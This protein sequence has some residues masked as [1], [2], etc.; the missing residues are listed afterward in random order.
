MKNI[1]KVVGFVI[2]FM[3]INNIISYILNSDFSFS[4]YTLH[5]LY[6]TE[7][8]I[9]VLL[10]G[11]C[12]SY[13]EVDP[14]IINEKTN[15]KAFNLGTSE[16][17]YDGTY[18]LI[19]EANKN[20]NIKTI[21]LEMYFGVAGK[22]YKADTYSEETFIISDYM[23]PS[24]NKYLYLIN[25]CSKEYYISSFIPSS[26]YRKNLFDSKILKENLDLKFSKNYLN[27]K[28]DMY[29]GNGYVRLDGVVEGG[30]VSKAGKYKRIPQKAFSD[31]DIYYLNKIIKYCK[32]NQIELVAYSSPMPDY[33][34]IQR[35]NYDEYISQVKSLFE[36][37][38]VEYYDFNLLKPEYFDFNIQYFADDEHL[39]SSGTVIFTTLFS[40]FFYGKFKDKDIFYSSYKEK[41]E[42]DKNKQYGISYE[43]VPYENNKLI[44]LYNITTYKDIKMVI[45]HNQNIDNI[46]QIEPN[47]MEIYVDYD[48][49]GEI[50]VQ[51]VTSNNSVIE[52]YILEVE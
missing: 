8:N 18:A 27:Y 12:H 45:G 30:Y 34:L 38:D 14:S 43:I 48:Y 24:L 19:K 28:D 21:Y 36:N 11:S 41:I 7:D 2:V 10:V 37:N 9:D 20:N 47:Y 51:C 49:V 4:R 44:K 1:V 33:N 15:I 32:E 52:N 25:S 50:E 6:T 31:D 42:N 3:I 26:R 39:N 5:E 16:Q 23:K 13:Y 40:D 22:N 35:G 46:V 17:R 29:A